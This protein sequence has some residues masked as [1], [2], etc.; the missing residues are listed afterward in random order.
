MSRF[1]GFVR[2]PQVLGMQQVP[3]QDL[4]PQATRS[5]AA[6]TG[7]PPTPPACIRI[8]THTPEAPVVV[9]KAATPDPV[10]MAQ[11]VARMHRGGSS[12]GRLCQDYPAGPSTVAPPMVLWLLHCRE[13]ASVVAVAPGH[14]DW[15]RLGELARDA[16]G[17]EFFSR[18][19]FSIQH[20]NRVLLYGS[21]IPS[22]PHGAIIRAVSAP[23]ASFSSWDAPP[24]P[25]AALHFDYDICFGPA[26]EQPLPAS[27]PAR[28]ES[29]ARGGHQA[30]G[31]STRAPHRLVSLLDSLMLHVINCML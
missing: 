21:S 22:P 10:L 18:G 6:W 20:N 2:V 3:P 19:G 25:I 23:T 15:A 26:G 12:S 5:V 27:T 31:R 7:A 17:V 11:N 14:V 29:P 8:F 30:L 16:F 24:D 4:P 1:L 28:G 9:P 13:R